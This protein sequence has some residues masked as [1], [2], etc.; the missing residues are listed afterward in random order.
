MAGAC[1]GA[2]G[3]AGACRAVPLEAVALP[4]GEG[5]ALGGAGM[6]GAGAGLRGGSGAMGAGGAT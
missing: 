2:L 6:G 1:A 3:T 4:G 5:A